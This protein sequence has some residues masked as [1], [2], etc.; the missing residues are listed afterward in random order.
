MQDD[1]QEF[2]AINQSRAWSAEIGGGVDQVRVLCQCRR[3]AP[4]TRLLHHLE[5]FCVRSFN[6]KTTGHHDEN[7][8]S[9]GQDLV[10]C[11]YPGGAPWLGEDILAAGKLDHFRNPVTCDVEWREPFDADHARAVRDALDATV[12]S[13]ESVTQVRGKTKALR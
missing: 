13:R 1:C 11:H 2:D 6:G 9:R 8:R 3:K 5:Q 4:L 7:V 12:H 10:P